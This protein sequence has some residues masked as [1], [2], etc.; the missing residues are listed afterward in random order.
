MKFTRILLVVFSLVF[1]SACGN[2][3]NQTKISELEAKIS[4]L[5]E[6]LKEATDPAAIRTAQTELEK[7]A[8]QKLTLMNRNLMAMLSQVKDTT[9][10][11]SCDKLKARI[12]QLDKD[13]RRHVKDNLVSVGGG[14]LEPFE[15]TASGYQKPG[16]LEAIPN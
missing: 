16:L 4:T 12:E 2:K 14:I 9:D 11:E 8:M 3:K 1:L 6:K 13:I 7:A 15:C 10:Q 5:Q